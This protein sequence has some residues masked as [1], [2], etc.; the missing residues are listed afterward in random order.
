MVSIF[1]KV[2]ASANA[3]DVAALRGVADEEGLTAKTHQL[4]CSKEGVAFLQKE[5][6]EMVSIR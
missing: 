5:I 6:A 1:A 3:L 4:L 2:A